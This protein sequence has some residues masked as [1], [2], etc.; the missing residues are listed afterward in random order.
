MTKQNPWQNM[1]ESVQ[2]KVKNTEGRNIYWITDIY[3]N[4]GISFRKSNH[5]DKL[6]NLP[7]LKGILLEKRNIG[8]ERGELNIIL[9]DKNEADLFLVLCN[10]L[11]SAALD[12][13]NDN[14]A[15]TAVENRLIRWQEL[16][17]KERL[18][19][20][21]IE[22]QMGLF[23][24]LLCLRDT[25]IPEVGFK[26][27]ITSWVGVDYDKQDFLLNNTAIEVKSYKTSKSETVT[28]SSKYQL[29]NVKD[30]VIL[31]SYALTLSDAGET[32][33]DIAN[34]IREQL[35]TENINVLSLFETKLLEGDFI[36]ELLEKPLQGFIVDKKKI[37]LVHE[38][39][40]RL[41]SKNIPSMISKLRYSIEL[42]Y[43]SKFE[44]T[45]DQI[46]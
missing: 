45:E 11:I 15:I 44:I 25:V 20:L 33:L 10:N 41:E 13:E 36:P 21:S 3:G 12:F 24:E 31:I 42:T 30:K 32:I 18:T 6:N 28:I 26:M 14:A 27:G 2:R 38:D 40:P 39:F 4:Y 22:R 19:E 23:T 34:A 46:F 7:K 9:T 43:C 8:N 17:K 35:K 16:L 29:D 1:G 5:F 37:Y